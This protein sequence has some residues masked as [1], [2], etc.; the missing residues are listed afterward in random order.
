MSATMDATATASEADQAGKDDVKEKPLPASWRIP[1][2]ESPDIRDEIVEGQHEALA[3]L[4]GKTMFEIL[5]ESN[6]ED[7]DLDSD[8]VAS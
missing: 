4:Y 1:E 2:M 3:S 8:P 7:E 6:L 5:A